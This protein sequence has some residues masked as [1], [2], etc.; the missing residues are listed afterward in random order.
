MTEKVWFI[1]GASRGFGREWAIAALDRGDKV[2]A[3]ARDTAT[4]A[5]LTAK[6]GDALLPIRLDVTDREA[7]FAAVKQ[8][9]DHFG[10]LD[11]VVNNAGY[12]QFGFIEELSEAEARDQIE[13]NVFGALWVTQA[14][15]PYLRAQGSGH[16]IQVSSIGGI[17]AFPLV[18]IYHASKWA[19]EGLSQSLAQEVAPFGIKVTLIEPG[20]FST[21][22]A[23]SS[24]KHAT[25]LTDYDGARDAAQQ[26][27]AQR[28][29]KPGDPKASAAAVL[30]IVDSENPPLRVFFG[31]LPLQLAKADYESRLQLWD[32]W[33][34]VSVEAQ[35]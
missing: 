25:P 8:A 6:Y 14:A 5:D 16:I 35:G 19:L 23:G 13:T 26:A 11:I 28:S 9:H 34:P 4:L 21:D 33:Q 22:W 20:G 12:G 10:R 31:E 17:T 32:E 1:T 27:R 18:G 3:T 7:D 29:A 24:A 15:L 2:A 30:K